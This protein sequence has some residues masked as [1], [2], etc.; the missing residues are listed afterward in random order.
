MEILAPDNKFDFEDNSLDEQQ[1]DDVSVPD[2]RERANTSDSID[3]DTSISS[4]P[5][6]V[7][8]LNIMRELNHQKANRKFQ[9]MF[10]MKR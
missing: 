4:K 5:V 9:R 8:E 1:M 6:M 3:I 2:L 7:I 10:E